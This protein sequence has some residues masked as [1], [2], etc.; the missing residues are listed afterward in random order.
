[1]LRILPSPTL[2]VVDRVQR[3][4]DQLTR[5]SKIA[6]VGAGGRRIAP[7]VTTF[8]AFAGPDVDVVG[9]IHSMQFADN[10]FDC[11][12][13]TGTLELVPN[14]WRAIDEI[15]RIVRPGRS[16]YFPLKSPRSHRVASA[17]YFR[18]A[19]PIEESSIK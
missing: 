4:L 13:C 3:T 15:H 10:S 17:V 5:G 2:V 9:D 8:D 12:C 1:M 7:D 14:P 11:I 6:D 18:G 19:K 16:D